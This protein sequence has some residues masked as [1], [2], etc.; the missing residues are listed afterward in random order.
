MILIFDSG[1]ISVYTVRDYAGNIPLSHKVEPASSITG[2]I[3]FVTWSPD[4][5]AFFVGYERGWALWSVYGKPGA[6][7]FWAERDLI[8]KD[9]GEGYLDGL[10]D[11][12]WP[13]GQDLLL[14][15]Y[16]GDRRLW[17]IEMAKS[18]ITGCYNA[19]SG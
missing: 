14:V 7:C 13:G 12:C 4:G 9:A 15:N 10:R 5:Y 17:A 16:K 3:T 6:H 11:G 18:A 19:V 1:V 2:N 8:K